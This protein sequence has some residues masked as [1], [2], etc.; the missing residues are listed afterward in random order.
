MYTNG[1]HIGYHHYQ[2]HKKK[3]FTK[4][5]RSLNRFM[6]SIIY[7]G[8]VLGVIIF[9]PQLI[10]IWTKPSIDGVSLVSWLGMGIASTFW[11][12]YGIVHKA[13]PIIFANLLAASIQLLIIAGILIHQ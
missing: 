7:V 4:P 8:G 10:D 12:F 13:K 2:K 9:I 6:D 1:M 5:Q 3:E 11:L